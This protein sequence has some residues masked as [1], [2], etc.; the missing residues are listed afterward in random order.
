MKTCLLYS[1]GVDSLIAWYMLNKPDTLYVDLG[2]RYAWKERIAIRRLPPKPLIVESN[3]GRYFEK[4]D[5]HIPGRNL[6]LAMYAAAKG[7]DEI[8]LVAQKGE[9]GLPDR[10][11]V[12]FNQATSVLSWHFERE[13]HMRNP[14]KA[15]YKHEMIKWYL[16]EGLPASDLLSTVSCYSENRGSYETCN[17]RGGWYDHCGQCPACLRKYVALTYNGVECE[18]IFEGDVESWGRVHYLPRIDEYDEERA[19]V[20]IEVLT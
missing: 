5:A 17:G 1:G 7:Y 19:R 12:F 16:S 4:A 10:S 9:Q 18:H 20:M 3:Y 11:I 2:H 6:L 13:I 8:Y 14:A 15:M